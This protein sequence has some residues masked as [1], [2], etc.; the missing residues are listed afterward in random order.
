MRPRCTTTALVNPLVKSYCTSLAFKCSPVPWKL[1]LSSCVL[2]VNREYQA[3]AQTSVWVTTVIHM[4]VFSDAERRYLD[5]IRREGRSPPLANIPRVVRWE[6]WG[7]KNTRAFSDEAYAVLARYGSRLVV[8]GG[9]IIDFNI[10][11]AQRDVLQQERVARGSVHL[12]WFS[13]VLGLKQK[14]SSLPRNIEISPT[15]RLVREPTVVSHSDLFFADI[16]TEL[17]Y[18]KTRALWDRRQHAPVYGGEVWVACARSDV[19]FDFLP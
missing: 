13:R 5:G 8:H 2:Q 19:R 7:P 10:W 18:V 15:A 6:D 17:P 1:A 4:S 14:P 11:G 3:D 12:K 9:R 16:V